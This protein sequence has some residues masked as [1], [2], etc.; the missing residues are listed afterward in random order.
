M[1]E[2]NNS[3]STNTNVQFGS[4]EME[5]V[6]FNAQSCSIPGIQF[7]PPKIGGRGGVQINLPA[8]TCTY[9]DLII[10]MP[11]DKEWKI[12]DDIYTYFLETMNVDKGTFSAKSFDMWLDI[13]TGKGK[14]VK[15]FWFYG[16]R[17]NDI[18]EIQVD[19]SDAEDTTLEVSLS[20]QFDY[21]E[22]DNTFFQA[23]NK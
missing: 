19:V 16:C 5:N 11:I 21:M 17:L 2:F 13:K 7:S 6:W 1:S 12:Y 22:M 10:D 20:F 3:Y 14:Q 15:K 4:V 9:T 8:D 18:S 23:R